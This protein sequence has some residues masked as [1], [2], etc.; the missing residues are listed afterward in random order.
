MLS[1]Y[2]GFRA[3]SLFLSSILILLLLAPSSSGQTPGFPLQ[4]SLNKPEDK[5]EVQINLPNVSDFFTPDT[6]PSIVR[7][8]ILLDGRR[9]FAI[10]A[11]KVEGDSESAEQE[12]ESIEVRA[13]GIET[14]LQSI[15][16]S[17]FNPETLDVIY[18]IDAKS[19]LP[20][21]YANYTVDGKQRTDRLL[22]VTQLDARIYRV[23]PE[24]WAE[25]LSQRIEEGLIRAKQER[26]P[27]FLQ[28]QGILAVGIL[29]IMIASSLA[30][31]NWQQRLQRERHDL[32]EQT[33]VTQPITDMTQDGTQ[34]VNTALLQQRVETRQ[35]YK[36]NDI[37]RR[38]LQTAQVII[39]V[40]GV[41]WIMGLFPYIRQLQPLILSWLQIPFKIL[42]VC[43]A[44]YV[45]V[46]VGEVS[47]ERFFWILQKSTNLAREIPKR[48]TL[49]F[50][51]F[52]RVV[53]GV[54]GVL[55]VGAGVITALS[56]IG[57]EVGPLLAG[58]GII[59]L[60]ISFASQSL[61]KDVINGFFIL[62]EDQYGV[63]DVIIVGDVAGLVENMNLR[64]TQ[65]RNEEGRL[66]TVPNSAITIVQ[67]L[68]KEWSRVDL[69]INVAYHADINRALQVIDKVAQDMSRDAK[70]Q[71]LILEP[72]LLLGID[73]L[74]YMGAMVRL[75]I[76]TQPLKQWEVAREY[77]RRLKLAFDEADIPIGVPQQALSLS[78]ADEIEDELAQLQQKTA[79]KPIE[80]P[81]KGEGG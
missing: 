81:N 24:E 50:S 36:V 54:L 75:W 10:A 23:D 9:L 47:V 35:R 61:I 11:P 68:S 3:I 65:L 7:H 70:W 38:L 52:S 16:A 29:L 44:T 41:F 46:R 59:G 17:D 19:N 14:R 45:L 33:Q 4:P 28:Q 77:R 20:V 2:R 63:G 55:L 15:V 13:E 49:R 72:P 73:K 53:K 26:Q 6:T 25:T 37:Q 5:P 43:L 76:K 30:F 27:E 8:P 57:I 34:T 1:R 60:G 80:N 22:T 66:I 39:W 32:A 78:N 58:A 74:D 79:S 12:P 40:G 31:K 69:T 42:A 64:I 56:I 71:D 48:A 51:T 21:L 18:E 67:N 62:L